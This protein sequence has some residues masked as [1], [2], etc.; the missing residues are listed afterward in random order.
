M[1]T[2]TKKVWHDENSEPPKNY[3]WAKGG[4]LYKNVEGQWKEVS[5]KDSGSGDDSSASGNRVGFPFVG[6]NIVGYVDSINYDNWTLDHG[7]WVIT[8]TGDIIAPEDVFDYCKNKEQVV[9]YPV[10]EY[11]ENYDYNHSNYKTQPYV[12]G[13]A[14]IT[15]SKYNNDFNISI[16]PVEE[17]YRAVKDNENYI[18]GLPHGD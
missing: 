4:K 16:A 7:E 6:G 3:L 12:F 8:I 15:V 14:S 11:D 13:V 17:S 10:L 1:E 18:M 2:L 5:K 9:L